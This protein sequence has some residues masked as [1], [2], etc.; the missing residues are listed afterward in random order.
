[1]AMVVLAAAAGYFLAGLALAPMDRLTLAAR[2]IARSRDFRRRVPE[3]RTADEVGR[4]A[5]TFNEMLTALEEAYRDLA[6]ALEARK[7]FLAD[8]SHELRTPLTIIRGNVEILQREGGQLPP[9]ER[10]EAL[11][12][13]LG[14][15][16]RMGAL[17]NDLLVLARADVGQHLQRAPLHLRPVVSEAMRKAARLAPDVTVTGEGLEALDVVVEGDAAAIERALLALLDNACKYGGTPAHVTVVGRRGTGRVGVAVRD[18]G[19]G[20]SPEDLPFI[21]ERF[22]RGRSSGG[23]PGTGLGL[24]IARWVAREHGGDVEV[25]TGPGGTTFT[26]WL[27]VFSG[28]SQAVGV[29]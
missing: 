23:R 14:E 11:R 22:Y 17:L 15:A 8:V 2:D 3:P 1:M 4:L 6:G 16:E 12:D 18:T 28:N 29:G 5:R 10:D 7:R 20:I 24:P 21:F 26:L 25:D 9:E 13:I 27:P 19:P